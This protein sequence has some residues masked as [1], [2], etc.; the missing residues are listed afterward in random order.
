VRRLSAKETQALYKRTIGENAH[1]IGM[2]CIPCNAGPNGEPLACAY[3][4]DHLG[5]HSWA[6]LPTFTA[7]DRPDKDSA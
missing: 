6:T 1:R 7:P 3:P 5:D 2:C 4:R